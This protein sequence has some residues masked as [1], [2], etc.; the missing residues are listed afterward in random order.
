M[1]E[2]QNIN[3]QDSKQLQDNEVMP[4]EINQTFSE[5]NSQE[6]E[7]SN[8]SNEKNTSNVDSNEVLEA[9]SQENTIQEDLKE[10]TEDIDENQ[11]SI[12]LEE[13]SE[14]QT[15][16]FEEKINHFKKDPKNKKIKLSLSKIKEKF[17]NLMLPKIRK[18]LYSQSVFETVQDAGSIFKMERKIGDYLIL[19]AG[20][21]FLISFIEFILIL[22]LFPLKEKEPYL[23]NFTN[24]TQSFAIIQ[25][26]DQSITANEALNRQLLGAYILNRETINRIDDKQ[27]S[28]T[29]KEQSSPEVWNVFERIVAQEDSIYSNK[30]LTRVVKIINIA[31]IKKS[32]ANADVSISLYAG[33]VLKSEKRYRIVISY[34]F[35]TI[36]IDYNSL[37]KNPTGFTVTGYAITEIAIIKELPD[38][39]KIKQSKS[40]I[41]YK[42]SKDNQNEDDI[43]NDDAYFYQDSDKQDNLNSDDSH[44]SNDLNSNKD[45]SYNPSSSYSDSQNQNNNPNSSDLSNLF[46]SDN[47]KSQNNQSS[48]N[49]NTNNSNNMD[50]NNSSKLIQK[51]KIKEQLQQL[52][53][54]IDQNQNKI[55][56]EDLKDLQREILNLRI[57]EQ[58]LNSKDSSNNTK[59]TNQNNFNNSPINKPNE[60]QNKSNDLPSPF[61]NNDEMIFK[62][63]SKGILKPFKTSLNTNDSLHFINDVANIKKS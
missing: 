10:N 22:T 48:S 44:H 19:I 8:N 6:F 39:N 31:I 24:D 9:N 23:V 12:V 38:E 61:S 28:D 18:N 1:L 55:P 35:K 49:A 30:N 25:K 57:Q 52:Q 32:Y 50:S 3:N 4:N 29:I 5:E 13:L 37:P 14:E 62:S 59:N 36:A 16:E 26:A 20:F 15:Q 42:N 33:G 7:N 56:Q 58:L 34:K 51:Q 54:L 40:R 53:M 63:H 46:K 47:T 45:N 2:N 21:F 60:V 41:K 27:R 11:E 17:T 43:L